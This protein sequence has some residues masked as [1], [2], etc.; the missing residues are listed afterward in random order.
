[1]ADHEVLVDNCGQHMTEQ[2]KH[3]QWP[4]I[5]QLQLVPVQWQ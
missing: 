2:Q 3:E 4:H 1:M 5:K